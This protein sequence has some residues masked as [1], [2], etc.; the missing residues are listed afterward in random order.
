MEQKYLSDLTVA[1]PA[2]KL[3]DIRKASINEADAKKELGG[4]T[5]ADYNLNK[6]S[7]GYK[8]ARICMDDDFSK[9]SKDDK[10]ALAGPSNY[11]TLMHLF[12]L[13]TI[14]S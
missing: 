13:F 5:A 9:L 4:I 6:L 1:C 8:D 3:G 12:K 2:T 10:E 11:K 14:Y 7:Q